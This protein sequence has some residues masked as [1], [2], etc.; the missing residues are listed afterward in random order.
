[1][2][3][4][5]VSLLFENYICYYMRCKYAFVYMDEWCYMYLPMSKFEHKT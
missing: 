3:Q 2:S 5:K 1:M 4:N